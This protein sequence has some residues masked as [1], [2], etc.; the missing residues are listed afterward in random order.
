MEGGITAWMQAEYPI[1]TKNHYVSVEVVDEELLM[2][3]EPWLLYQADCISCQNQ[4]CTNASTPITNT[5]ITV[6]EENEN[7]TIYLFS[8]L[9]NGTS[10][11]YT[12]TKS[13]LWSSSELK[14]GVNRT[15][16][17][18]STESTIEGNSTQIFNLKYQAQHQDYNVTVH[19]TLIPSDDNSYKG[20]IT[21]IGYEPSGT[22]AVKSKEIIVVN[23]SVTLSDHYK[24]LSTVMQKLGREYIQSED[25]ALR[26]IADNYFTMKSEIKPL[27]R[28]VHNDIPEYNQV[29]TGNITAFAGVGLS[30]PDPELMQNGSFESGSSY[31]TLGATGNGEYG[32]TN[33]DLYSGSYSLR[34]GWKYNTRMVNDRA[35]AY[36]TVTIPAGATNVQL[37]FII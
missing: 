7:Q 17:L 23:S 12:V 10:F 14:N 21:Q 36:Q 22:I 26:N 20:S 33:E 19:T 9:V 15:T 29:I 28:I 16:T 32:V 30:V 27:A 13:I 25:E 11:E 18:I 5:T 34:L 35:E 24:I 37:S 6:L 2:E 8:A 3:I 4:T 1:Y 31:W